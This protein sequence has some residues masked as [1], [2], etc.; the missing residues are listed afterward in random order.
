MPE[1]GHGMAGGAEGAPQ[2][3]GRDSLAQRILNH[4]VQAAGLVRGP[5]KMKDFF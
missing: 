3:G 4:D 2:L 1:F 5:A